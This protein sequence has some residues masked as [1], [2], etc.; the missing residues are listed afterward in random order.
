LTHSPGCLDLRLACDFAEVQRALDSMRRFLTEQ[1]CSSELSSRCEIAL[2]EAC[3]NAIK[4][5]SGEAR[6][7]PVAVQISCF[8]REIEITVVDHTPGCEWP[9]QAELPPQDSE[10]GRGI[11]LIQAVMDRAEYTT[12]PSGNRLVMRKLRADNPS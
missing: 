2:A 12:H 9:H 5:A 7:R 3:N 10:S 8:P 1:G 6:S 11:C 4:Y